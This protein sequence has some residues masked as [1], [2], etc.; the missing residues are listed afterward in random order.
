[1]GLVVYRF[2]VAALVTGAFSLAQASLQFVLVTVGGIAIGLLVG[3]LYS[4]LERR[5]DDSPVEITLSFLVP[6]AAYIPAEQFGGSGVLAAVT[7][8]IFAGRRSHEVLSPATRLQ[9]GAVWSMLVFILNGLAF[10][11]VGLQLR[12]LLD[13]LSHERYT[14]GELLG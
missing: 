4:W 12:T 11:L 3:W 13:L 2:A 10:I 8:G 7:A 6:F 9:A 5:L 14:A 1:T